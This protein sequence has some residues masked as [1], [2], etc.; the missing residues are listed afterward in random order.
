MENEDSLR[1]LRDEF[2][3]FLSVLETFDPLDRYFDLFL[4]IFI[5]SVYKIGWLTRQV[6]CQ[7]SVT[8]EAN[9]A[10]VY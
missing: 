9:L 2:S 7:S 6:S 3:D 5:H 1:S 10:R 8:D 4:S